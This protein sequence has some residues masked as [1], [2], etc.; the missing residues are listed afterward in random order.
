MPISGRDKR[1]ILLLS[2]WQPHESQP[3]THISID[4]V[5]ENGKCKEYIDLNTFRLFHLKP[6]EVK[7]FDITRPNAAPPNRDIMPSSA[8]GSM[9]LTQRVVYYSA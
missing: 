2:T 3:E 8:F 7:S 1:F 9:F 6:P 4:E 5:E